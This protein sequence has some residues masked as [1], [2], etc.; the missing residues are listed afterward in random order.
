MTTLTPMIKFANVTGGTASVT[1][2][3]TATMEA[4]QSYSIHINS[5]RLCYQVMTIPPTMT[6]PLTTLTPYRQIG[7][8]HV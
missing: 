8:A 1:G 2:G 5:A 7:R 3:G 6:K 4:L